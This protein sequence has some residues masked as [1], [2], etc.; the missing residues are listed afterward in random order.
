[1]G[2][3]PGGHSPANCSQERH[4]ARPWRNTGRPSARPHS[5]SVCPFSN[6]TGKPERLSNGAA[7]RRPS[8][9]GLLL[10]LLLSL[11]RPIRL[12]ALSLCLP[13]CGALTS[14]LSLWS[15]G[16]CCGNRCIFRRTPPPLRRPLEGLDSSVQLVTFCDQQVEDLVNRHEISRVTRRGNGISPS[17]ECRPLPAGGAPGAGQNP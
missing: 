6:G 2:W 17:V 13:L 8:V 4:V 12:H 16:N 3:E 7:A 10:R 14:P 11:R 15:R 9:T 1:M 5:K